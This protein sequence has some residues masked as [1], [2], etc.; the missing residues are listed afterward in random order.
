MYPLQK[1][2]VQMHSLA[3]V[4]K[5]LA[6]RCAMRLTQQRAHTQSGLTSGRTVAGMTEITRQVL[7]CER[8]HT[9]ESISHSVAMSIVNGTGR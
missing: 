7:R 1:Q 6:V 2:V 8:T 5:E 9:H 4:G 3:W